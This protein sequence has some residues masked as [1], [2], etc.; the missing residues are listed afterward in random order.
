MRYLL[1]LLMVFCSQSAFSATAEKPTAFQRHAATFMSKCA[2]C[3]TIGRGNRVGPDLRGV[4]ERREKDWLIGFMLDPE[5]YLDSDPA[6]KKMLEEFNGVRMEAQ[7]LSRDDAEGILEYIQAASAG[8]LTPEDED[9]PEV[10]DPYSKLAMPSE[11]FGLS[12]AGILITV[13]LLAAA[14]I[15]WQLDFFKLAVLLA[16]LAGFSCYLSLGG[17][18]HHRLLGNQQGYAPRQPINF[19]HKLHAGELNVSC[20]YCHHGAEKSDVAG[21]ASVDTCM[22]CHQAVR[23]TQDQTR[24]SVELEKLVEQWATRN[25]TAPETVG[26]VRVHDLP[27]YVHFSHKNH[28]RNN[29]QCQECHGPVQEMKR[30]R[31]AA[32]LS[33]GWCVDCHRQGPGKAPTH[34]KRSSGPLDCAACHW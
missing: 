30:V 27:D 11:S 28:V 18:R 22:N 13:V 25:S 19:S 15:L 14:G 8:P 16:V 2:K 21:V 9:T 32:N 23:K 33:M 24:P 17:R 6:A 20:L 7:G 3:H 34:W 1:P 5:A 4:A 12:R 26:W 31:Q 29:I 10:E